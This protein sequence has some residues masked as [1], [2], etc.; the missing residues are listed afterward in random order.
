MKCGGNKTR[1]SLESSASSLG[2]V[3]FWKPGKSTAQ[4]YIYTILIIFTP[5]IKAENLNSAV[6]T[7]Q[8]L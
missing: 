2:K 8:N 5:K 3:A 1:Q 6:A 7:N 4:K